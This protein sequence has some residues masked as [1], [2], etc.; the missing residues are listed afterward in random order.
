[1]AR[2]VILTD[3]TKIQHCTDATTTDYICVEAS[4]Y[5]KA[6]KERDKFNL[7]NSQA[8]QVYNAVDDS[9][10]ESAGD[11]VL[12]P[13]CTITENGGK[14]CVAITLRTKTEMELMHEEIGEL[15]EVVL[16]A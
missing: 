5:E 2:Y 1:M 15:Q 13:G 8:I 7:E 16:D 3:N 4:S 10:I 11:L 12:N 14:F 6:G 9:L